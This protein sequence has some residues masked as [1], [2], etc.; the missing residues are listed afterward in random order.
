MSRLLLEPAL[1]CICRKPL[2]PVDAF[3]QFNMQAPVQEPKRV[4][5]KFFLPYTDNGQ[6]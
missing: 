3:S 1:T 4:G 6:A 5:K 2:P